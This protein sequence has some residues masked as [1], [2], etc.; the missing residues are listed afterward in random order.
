MPIVI[1]IQ[2]ICRRYSNRNFSS[3]PAHMFR[4]QH[5][6][7]KSYVIRSHWLIHIFPFSGMV[8]QQQPTFTVQQPQVI[9]YQVPVTML[10]PSPLVGMSIPQPS[11]VSLPTQQHQPLLITNN[12][13]NES[14][15]GHGSK[16]DQK[17]KRL[18]ITDPNTNK[19]IKEIPPPKDQKNA[20]E[21]GKPKIVYIEL[22][23]KGS[24]PLSF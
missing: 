18:T 1:R 16:A 14:L 24:Y 17:S 7:S 2:V 22:F 20:E 12:Q 10:Y 23:F 9:C 5:Q 19:E 8:H 13:R 21:Q 11:Q 4:H 6:C 15:D 3:K